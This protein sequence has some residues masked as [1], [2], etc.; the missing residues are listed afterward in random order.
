MGV[1]LKVTVETGPATN[2]GV[3]GPRKNGAGNTTFASSRT[4]TGG[5]GTHGPITNPSVHQLMG[6]VGPTT[7]IGGFV[8]AVGPTT[9]PV[10][11]VTTGADA[12]VA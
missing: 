10:T 12:G 8:M 4:N 11:N 9:G 1:A 2:S 3:I 6:G 7:T 5:N